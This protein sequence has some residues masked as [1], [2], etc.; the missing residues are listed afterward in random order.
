MG[1]FIVLRFERSRSSEPSAILQD[2]TTGN[3]LP[4]DFYDWRDA[5]HYLNWVYSKSLSVYK[6]R[7][8]DRWATSYGYMEEEE[9]SGDLNENR[10]LTVDTSIGII[11][12][13]IDINNLSAWTYNEEEDEENEKEDEESE[14]ENEKEDEESEEEEEENEEEDEESEEED[15]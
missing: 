12:H 9:F 2:D 15:E 4:Y 7:T 1:Y 5:I 13:T 14:E 10:K 6:Q 3:Y 8:F 11:P